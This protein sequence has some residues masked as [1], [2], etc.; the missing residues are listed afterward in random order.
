MST[1]ETLAVTGSWREVAA[2]GTLP[3]R[4]YH[5]LVTG[6]DGNVYTF[7]GL[8]RAAAGSSTPWQCTNSVWQLQLSNEDYRWSL[9]HPGGAGG[10]VPCPRNEACGAVVDGWLWVFGGSA[11][12]AGAAPGGRAPG[13]GHSLNDLWRYPLPKHNGDGG[14]GGGGRA[15][16]AAA[17]PPSWE[18]VT[19]SGAPCP[20][21]ASGC[22][23][24]GTSLIIF[25]GGGVET[26][27]P[28]KRYSDT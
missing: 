6:A 11:Q 5:L 17:A 1:L 18:K 28:A 25:G 21:C 9:L 2:T 7:G 24:S 26:V 19:A 3:E 4:K 15:A 22:A 14:A 27:A 10:E 20:R 8:H 13:Q 12:S 23:A 16:A